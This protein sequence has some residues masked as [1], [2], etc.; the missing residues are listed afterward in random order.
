[1]HT[2]PVYNDHRAF[3]YNM[4]TGSNILRNS[5]VSPEDQPSKVIQIFILY[6]HSRD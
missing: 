1:M 2:P 4:N 6:K 3:T 5:H